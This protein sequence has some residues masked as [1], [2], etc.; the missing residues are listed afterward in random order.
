MSST[1]WSPPTYCNIGK[2]FR[3][4]WG[5]KFEFKNFVKFVHKSPS[6]LF[7]TSGSGDSNNFN[8][9]ANVKY[10]D[11]WGDVETDLDS[12][13]K[14]ESK[15][16]LTKLVDGGKATF[17]GGFSGSKKPTDRNNFSLK[18]GFEESQD[19]F[20]GSAL[21]SLDEI[22]KGNPFAANVTVSGT[23]GFEG[24]T[25]GGE[26]KGKLDHDP[27]VN[28]HNVG[29]QYQNGPWTLAVNTEK[30]TDVVRAS[31]FYQTPLKDYS[32]GVEV[33]SDEYD[34]L[35][36][37]PQK[38]ILNVVTQYEYNP[39]LTTKFRWSNGGEFGFA[40]EHRLK[41]P[42]ISLLLSSNLKSKGTDVRLDK[43]GVGFSLGDYDAK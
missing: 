35:P 2:S 13:G 20:T 31:S 8:G 34:H 18:A 29:A 3:D 5:K 11:A 28:D 33:I 43:F 10:T 17:S 22:D 37:S 36:S 21:A 38:K 7:T 15:A 24:V 9:S 39:D 12:T 4:L 1:K 27:Q 16:T 14:A 19:W 41:N 42:N 32:V 6:F 40:L 26:V 25:L 23:I 30:Q